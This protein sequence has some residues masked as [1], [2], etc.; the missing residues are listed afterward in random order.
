MPFV[1]VASQGR[2][3]AF[4]ADGQ[5][6]AALNIW[7]LSSEQ[8]LSG[9]V[10]RQQLAA[11]CASEIV[12]LLNGGQQGRAGFSRDGQLQ[13]CCPRISPSLGP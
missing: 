10:Y 9:A 7:Q 4:Q 1:S 6:Q 8:P 13:E 3:E 2:K 5:P 11:S 12:G